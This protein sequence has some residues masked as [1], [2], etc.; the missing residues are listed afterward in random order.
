[1]INALSPNGDF[2]TA[3]I[4]AVAICPNCAEPL[5]PK[6]GTIRIWHWAHSASVDCEPWSE[7]ETAW[8]L[9]W[10]ANVSPDKREQIFDDGISKHRADAIGSMGNVIEFQHSNVSEREIVARTNFYSARIKPMIWVVDASEFRERLIHRKAHTESDE[11]GK[12]YD[13]YRFKQPRRCWEV[14]EDFLDGF[15]ELWFDTCQG[16]RKSGSMLR[17]S[18]IYREKEWVEES[19]W[20][21]EGWHDCTFI[22]AQSYYRHEF[23]SLYFSDKGVKV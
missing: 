17:V 23:Q 15:C 22:K 3:A 2:I 5:I 12:Q 14:L 18:R 19:E 10:K 1:M 20:N 16:T 6:R 4:R 11:Y 8:H 13:T 21:K 9:H 7:G